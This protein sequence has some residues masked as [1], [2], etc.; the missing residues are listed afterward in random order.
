MKNP[1]NLATV[2]FFSEPIKKSVVLAKQQ[3]QE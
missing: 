3:Y 2:V 1:F